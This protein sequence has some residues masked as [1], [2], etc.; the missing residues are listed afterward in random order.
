MTYILWSS[1]VKMPILKASSYK[2]CPLSSDNAFSME[3][4]CSGLGIT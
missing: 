1:D 3:V 2:G 4:H